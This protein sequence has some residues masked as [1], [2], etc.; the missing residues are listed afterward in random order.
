[1]YVYMVGWLYVAMFV[2]TCL[3]DGMDGCMFICMH[4]L[5]VGWLHMHAC[6]HACMHMVWDNGC[7]Y[8]SMYA[9]MFV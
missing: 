4:V 5:L 7:M 3:Y 8:V 1:M 6:L 9:C 2:L